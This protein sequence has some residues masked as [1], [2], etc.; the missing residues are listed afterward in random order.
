MKENVLFIF[1]YVFIV[2]FKFIFSICVY[3]PAVVV[4]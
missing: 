2:L 1:D 3:F 4:T